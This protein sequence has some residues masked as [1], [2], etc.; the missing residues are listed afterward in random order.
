MGQCMSQEAVSYAAKCGNGQ[1]DAWETCDCGGG[2]EGGSRITQA[3][4]PCCD[5]NTCQLKTGM[6]EWDGRTLS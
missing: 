1:I 3:N 6:V 5:C 4:D 2:D